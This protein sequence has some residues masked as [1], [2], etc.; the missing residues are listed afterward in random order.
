MQNSNVNTNIEISK[1]SIDLAEKICQ[2]KFEEHFQT[3]F[4]NNQ[5]FINKTKDQIFTEQ[6]QLWRTLGNTHLN[7][8]DPIFN[9]PIKKALYYVC[10]NKIKWCTSKLLEF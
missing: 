5:L 6:I 9:T 2:K 10:N 3:K 4:D 7:Q 8:S 1:E